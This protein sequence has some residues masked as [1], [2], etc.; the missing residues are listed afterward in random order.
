MMRPHDV[1]CPKIVPDA[2]CRA[3][4]TAN[5]SSQEEKCMPALNAEPVLEQHPEPE[6]GRLYMKLTT[7]EVAKHLRVHPSMVCRMAKRGELPGF[8][9]GSAWRFDRAQIEAWM[10]SRIYRPES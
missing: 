3:N 4:K 2:R 8:K 1:G 9:I 5:V 10:R 6:P 7:V